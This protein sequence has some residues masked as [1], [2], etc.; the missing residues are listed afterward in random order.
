PNRPAPAGVPAAVA[1]LGGPALRSFR[2]ARMRRAR[3]LAV[4]AIGLMGF[5]SFWTVV[6]IAGLQSKDFV[7]AFVLLGIAAFPW[8]GGV[9]L[10][11]RARGHRRRAHRL[12]R[13]VVA[14]TVRRATTVE[15]LASQMRVKGGV[16]RETALEAMELGVV[17]RELIR[18][19]GDP[20]FAANASSSPLVAPLPIE[21]WIGR[22]LA[23]S[24]QVESL[25]ARGGVGAV[26][27]GRHVETKRPCAIK[28]LLPNS[29]GDDA[30]RRFE[31]E[32][33]SASKLGHPGIVRTLDFGRSDDGAAFLVMELLEGETLEARLQRKGAL[34]WRDALVVTR[35]IGDALAC[36]HEGGLLHRD[37]KPA[38]IFLAR[39]GDAERSILLD[40]GLVK[41]LDETV[42]SRVTVSGVVAGTPLYMSP[43]QASGDPLDVR[44]DIYTLGVVLYEMLTGTPPFFDRTVAQVYA[45]LLREDAPRV[46]ALAPGACPPALDDAIARALA[47]SPDGRYATVRA[48][49]QA[50]DAAAI[51]PQ[52]AIGA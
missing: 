51:E 36:A 33:T 29:L 39:L 8:T 48:F 26:F 21:S 18:H 50:L 9:V 32:A 38:N 28:V 20:S 10:I 35:E 43:E 27:R 6:A 30:V 46:E 24:W 14:A 11:L 12:A 41:P 52:A 15:V 13:L 1:P 16:V 37:I 7:P 5:A 34:P 47:R 23:G 45:R 3:W 22:T 2:A 49:V 17:P 19:L 31:R 40:F 44:S 42:V 4:A 25:L